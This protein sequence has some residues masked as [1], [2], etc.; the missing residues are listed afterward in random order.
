[1][2]KVAVRQSWEQAFAIGGLCTEVSGRWASA[3]DQREIASHSLLLVEGEDIEAWSFL[4][5]HP[6]APC[7]VWWWGYTPYGN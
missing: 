5:D 7:Y 2:Q 3:H 4:P 6:L 1:M